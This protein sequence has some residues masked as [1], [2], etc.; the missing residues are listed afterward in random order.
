VHIDILTFSAVGLLASSQHDRRLLR[1]GDSGTDCGNEQARLNFR[2]IDFRV[3]DS[4]LAGFN[5]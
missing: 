4:V 3:I 1:G 5:N 2:R